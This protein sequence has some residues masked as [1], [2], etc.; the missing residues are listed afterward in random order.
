MPPSSQAMKVRGTRV[1]EQGYL[2]VVIEVKCAD[3]VLL[4]KVRVGHRLQEA[5]KY[6]DSCSKMSWNKDCNSDS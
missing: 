3:A 6:P 1:W 4:T 2:N 5:T